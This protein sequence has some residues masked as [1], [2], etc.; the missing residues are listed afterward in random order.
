M[1]NRGQELPFDHKPFLYLELHILDFLLYCE[2]SQKQQRRN[3]ELM[4]TRQ[5]LK[6]VPFRTFS[7]VIG[8]SIHLHAYYWYVAGNSLY[9]DT[10]GT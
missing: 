1:K 2:V 5:A 6:Q 3:Q 7:A 10:S 4:S 9:K 8:F